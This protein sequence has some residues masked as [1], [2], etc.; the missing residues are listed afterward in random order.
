MHYTVEE[1]QNWLAHRG[2]HLGGASEMDLGCMEREGGVLF[3]IGM[4]LG[5]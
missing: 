4:R 2:T 5:V 1:G 3:S